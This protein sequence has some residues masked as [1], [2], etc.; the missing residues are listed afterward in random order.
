M[1]K[2]T[3]DWL[4]SIGIKDIFLKAKRNLTEDP[5]RN[6]TL[7]IQLLQRFELS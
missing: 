3:I 4:K 6:G 2:Q 7:L 5:L 1:E